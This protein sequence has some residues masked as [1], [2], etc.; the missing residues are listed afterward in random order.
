M[1]GIYF[2]IIWV[3]SA[4]LHTLYDLKIKPYLTGDQKNTDEWPYV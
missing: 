1:D 2:L 4:L 3:G